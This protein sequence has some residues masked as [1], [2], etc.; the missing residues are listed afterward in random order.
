MSQNSM[1]QI[2]PEEAIQRRVDYLEVRLSNVEEQQER[3]EEHVRNALRRMEEATMEMRAIREG[4]QEEQDLPR[5][6]INH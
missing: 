2:T 1:S 4:Q 3:T 6:K 5:G